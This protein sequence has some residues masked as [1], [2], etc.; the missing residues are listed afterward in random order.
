MNGLAGSQA[1][2]QFRRRFGDITGDG[3]VTPYD[4]QQFR[5]A[6]GSRAGQSRYVS[7]F[8]YN[9]NNLIA[10]GDLLQIRLRLQDYL[11]TQDRLK[12]QDRL[13]TK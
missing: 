13:H 4:M 10:S 6:Y 9:S 3:V 11:L 1:T 2:V 5:K 12:K 7:A 8:D